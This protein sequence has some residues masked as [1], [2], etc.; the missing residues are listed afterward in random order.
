MFTTEQLT[1]IRSVKRR[2]PQQLIK[3][4]QWVSSREWWMVG[5]YLLLLVLGLPSLFAFS[6]C[7]MIVISSF[8]FNGL[9]SLAAD[10]ADEEGDADAL[11]LSMARLATTLCAEYTWFSN[12]LYMPNVAVHT[13]HLYDRWAGFSVILWSR[14]TWFSSFHWYT[15]K[16]ITIKFQIL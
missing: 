11:F 14:A 8:I 9:R 6:G 13:V 4:R 1:Q 3:R 5:F 10:A 12:C 16:L 7:G 2:N 15:L